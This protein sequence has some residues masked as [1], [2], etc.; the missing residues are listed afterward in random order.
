MEDTKDEA[1]RNNGKPAK[2]Q[3]E[4]AGLGDRPDEL[5]QSGLQP[6]QLAAM[7]AH[8]LQSSLIAVSR[9]AELLRQ[10]GPELSLEQE[11]RLAG[12]ERTADRMKRL[13]A[14]MQN[15]ARDTVR[16]EPVGLDEVV[17]EVRETL[18]PLATDR[19]AEIVT[20]GP[21]PMV[22]ADRSQLV[23]LLQNLISNAIKFGPRRAGRV[24]VVAA[25]SSNAWRITVSDE[26][27]GI[28]LE[29]RERIF[30]PFRRLRGS[31]WQPGTGL[32][33]A[34]CKRVA[35][36]HGGSLVVQSHDGAGASFVVTLPDRVM[37]L[38]SVG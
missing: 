28:P 9:N 25:R 18:Q 3:L 37:D 32:G 35:E 4:P 1:I 30:E 34:I 33:L 26:G 15:L 5:R 27:P 10:A 7:V 12:I 8:D 23:Q 14:S 29:H 16:I 6:D 20:P 19:Q 2:A 21:L 22:L 38:A 36:N 17:A 13:L 24:T 31:R 11:D